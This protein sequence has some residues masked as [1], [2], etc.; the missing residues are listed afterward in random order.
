MPAALIAE[1]GSGKPIIG[2]VGEYDALPGIF[3]ES[4]TSDPLQVGAA[5]RG[6]NWIG[7]RNSSFKRNAKRP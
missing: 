5:G 7:W 3:A 1:F 4:T 6:T 2:I